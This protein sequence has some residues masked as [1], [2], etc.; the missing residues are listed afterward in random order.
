MR[1]K[2][3]YGPMDYQCDIRG[4]LMEAVKRMDHLVAQGYSVVLSNAD[5]GFIISRKGPV[6]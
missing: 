1:Y 2:I 3:Q 4:S 5:T 6:A